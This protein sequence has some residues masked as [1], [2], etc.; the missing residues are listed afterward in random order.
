MLNAGD[1][2]SLLRE[3]ASCHSEKAFA[4][5]V[6]RYVNLVYSAA[7][8]GLGNPSDAEEVTQVV[9]AILARKA[10]TLGNRT[11]LPGWLYSTARL[12]A[13][14]Y[15]RSEIRRSRREQEAQMQSMT[16]ERDS[17]HWEQLAPDLDEAM[18]SLSETDRNALILRF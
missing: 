18:S 10:G 6:S 7:L 4:T 14:N 16:D 15:L 17:D 5:L 8:R 11:V 1:D 13:S 3:Y 9:F 12:T 2:L